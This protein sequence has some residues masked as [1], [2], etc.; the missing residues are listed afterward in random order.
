MIK[1]S[2]RGMYLKKKKVEQM[3]QTNGSNQQKSK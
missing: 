3:Q 2:C 1:N